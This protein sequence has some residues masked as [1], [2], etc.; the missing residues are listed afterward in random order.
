MPVEIQFQGKRER[1]MKIY[2]YL[3]EMPEI[4]EK[5]PANIKLKEL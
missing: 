3:I 2:G 4:I 5:S 1:K